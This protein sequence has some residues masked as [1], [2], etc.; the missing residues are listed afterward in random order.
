MAEEN[1]CGTRTSS[2]YCRRLGV[3]VG[4]AENVRLSA[5]YGV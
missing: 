5:G 1:D 3:V 2:L 4:G